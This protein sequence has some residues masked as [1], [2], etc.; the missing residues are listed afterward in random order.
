MS[1]GL[2]V[3]AM[4]TVGL[5]LAG[6]GGGYTPEQ[7]VTVNGTIVKGGQP[8]QVP[9]RDVGLGSVEVQL[10]PTGPAAAGMGLETALVAEDGSFELRGAG[11]GIPPGKY[12]MAVYQHD[13]G[14]GSDALNGVFSDAK[15]PIEVEIPEDKIGSTHDLGVIDLDAYAQKK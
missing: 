5:V 14:P 3:C 4:F 7:G 15:T 9:R 13:Q 8:L 6:C 11:R 12:K 10:V 1:V 2:R